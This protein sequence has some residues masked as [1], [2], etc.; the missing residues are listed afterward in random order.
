MGLP[1]SLTYMIVMGIVMGRLGR[2]SQ[3]EGWR[4]PEGEVR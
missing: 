3:R 1:R 2:V 4:C